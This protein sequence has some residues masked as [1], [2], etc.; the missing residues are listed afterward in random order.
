MTAPFADADAKSAHTTTIQSV[1][2]AAAG[3]RNRIDPGI[4]PLRNPG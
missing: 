3:P 2:E 1:I 4:S